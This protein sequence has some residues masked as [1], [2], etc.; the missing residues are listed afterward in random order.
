MTGTL[1]KVAAFQVWM[2]LL[3]MHMECT[4]PPDEE[5]HGL[6]T[7]LVTAVIR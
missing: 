3:A 1:Q 4:R 2:Q 6:C 5:D 7:D